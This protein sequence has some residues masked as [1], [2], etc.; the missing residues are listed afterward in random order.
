MWSWTGGNTSLALALCD[1]YSTQRLEL[2]NNLYILNPSP[3]NYSIEK[4]LNIL[5][6]A[7]EDFNF[8][9]N[10]VLLKLQLNF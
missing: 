5:F 4:L 1:L 7:S 9:M 6:Y 3:K 10:K 2:L 8:N